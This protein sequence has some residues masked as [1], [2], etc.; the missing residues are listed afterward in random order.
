[1]QPIAVGAQT[2]PV[3]EKR[4]RPFWKF[5]HTSPLQPCY[6]T[7]ND[8]CPFKPIIILLPAVC[9]S[10]AGVSRS[11]TIV[12]AYLMSV[13]SMGWHE[14]LRYVRSVRPVVNP[15]LGFQR[16][17]RHF[18]HSG[19]LAEVPALGLPRVLD[20]YSTSKLLEYFLLHKYSLLSISGSKIPFPVA[21]F[22]R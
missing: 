10:F 21:V 22:C 8:L 4:E 14:A 15:N 6:A 18:Q 5:L 16:Q 20:Y 17:L 13:T 12:V 2:N 11:S 9:C 1:M 3:S 7:D 19:L